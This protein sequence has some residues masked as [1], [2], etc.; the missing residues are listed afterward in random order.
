MDLIEDDV[1]EAASPLLAVGV[2]HQDL[3]HLRD[4][5]EHWVGLCS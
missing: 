1:G 2:Q 4:G 3:Q 5:H